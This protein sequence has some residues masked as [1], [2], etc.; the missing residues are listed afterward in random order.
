VA[1]YLPGTCTGG[2]GS[3]VLD[4]TGDEPVLLRSGLL[5]WPPG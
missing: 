2:V 4:V 3:T 5:P 1:C